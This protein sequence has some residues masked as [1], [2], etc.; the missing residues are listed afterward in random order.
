M[1]DQDDT[2][3]FSVDTLDADLSFQ[4]EEP[5]LLDDD[6]IRLLTSLEDEL[7]SETD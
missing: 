3:I 2:F 5:E 6:D 1:E 4:T 7:D